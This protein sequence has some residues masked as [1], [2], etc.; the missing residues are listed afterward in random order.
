MLAP[1]DRRFHSGSTDFKSIVCE[2]PA[3]SFT[4]SLEKRYGGALRLNGSTLIVDPAR[5]SQTMP[6]EMVRPET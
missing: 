4:E 1:E 2:V 3:F 6:A 5:Y